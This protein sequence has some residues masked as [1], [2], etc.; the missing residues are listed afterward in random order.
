[1]EYRRW[2]KEVRNLRLGV[3]VR[4]LGKQEQWKHMGQRKGRRKTGVKG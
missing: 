4:E 1:M 3:R 2:K